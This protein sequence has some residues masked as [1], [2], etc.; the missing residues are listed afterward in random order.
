MKLWIGSLTYIW[1]SLMKSSPGTVP[2]L[3]NLNHSSQTFLYTECHNDG[4][5]VCFIPSWSVCFLLFFSR[6]FCLRVMSKIQ[7]WICCRNTGRIYHILLI[8]LIILKNWKRTLFCFEEL[9]EWH[10]ALLVIS[11][12]WHLHH[13]AV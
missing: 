8:L 6:A 9:F 7:S 4:T 5:S 10:I 3:G 2:S 12:W 11:W 1:K 13:T